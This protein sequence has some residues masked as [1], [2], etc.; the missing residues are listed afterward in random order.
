MQLSLG[1]LCLRGGDRYEC[2]FPIEVDPIV[3]GAT[4]YRVLLPD[5]VC[6]VVDRL[7][8]G[9]LVTVD[10]D[11]RLYGPC[12]RCL[13][14]GVLS[15]RAEQQEFAP[16]AKDGWGE[17]DISDFIKDL[18]VDVDGLA[19]EALVLGLPAQVVCADTCKGLCMRCGRDL[20]KGSCGCEADPIDERW[21]RLK[22]LRLEDPGRASGGGGPGQGPG[23]TPTP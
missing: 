8:G 4:D 13:G 2:I 22:D 17:T 5:G 14:E 21:N 6:V 20:N 19:R 23:D 10:V 15:V 9:Y 12:A 3:L 7:A 1:D 16:T 18:V 11:A